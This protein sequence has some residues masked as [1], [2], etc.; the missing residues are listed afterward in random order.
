[1]ADGAW[2]PQLARVGRRIDGVDGDLERAI[3]ENLYQSGPQ[4]R[5]RWLLTALLG[6][7]HTVR[8]L[9]FSWPLYLLGIAAVSLPLDNAAWL[10]VFFLPGILVSLLIL[11]RGV[12][13]DYRRFIHRVLLKPGATRHVLWPQ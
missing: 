3:C 9:L 4:Q 5:R 10:G 7:K 1:M 8:G 2:E 11:R 13:E 12:V 6:L